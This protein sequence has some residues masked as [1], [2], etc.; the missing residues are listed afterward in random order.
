LDLLR[1]LG[2]LG[3]L[4]FL[5]QPAYSR[6]TSSMCHSE[7]WKGSQCC[8]PIVLYRYKCTNGHQRTNAHQHNRATQS[9]VC[10]DGNDSFQGAICSILM[11]QLRFLAQDRII[12]LPSCCF[13]KHRSR[14][15]ICR[16]RE[17]NVM[18]ME[19][20]DGKSTFSRHPRAALIQ[21]SFHIFK[22]R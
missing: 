11:Q 8:I 6:S 16:D 12:V 15:D 7:Y 2:E 21:Y 4:P 1:L 9:S 10:P 17:R 18:G 19:E 14:V 20:N 22:F 3:D 13:L 5:L